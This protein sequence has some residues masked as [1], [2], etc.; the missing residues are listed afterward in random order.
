M[1]NWCMVVQ[2]TGPHHNYK[3]KT[4]TDERG[5]YEAIDGRAN[6]YDAD[7]LFKEFVEFVKSKNQNVTHATFTSGGTN[8]VDQITPRGET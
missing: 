6:D 1:G 3:K 5:T 7:L 4:V 8:T 2:G